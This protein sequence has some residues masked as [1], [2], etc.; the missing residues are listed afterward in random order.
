MFEDEIKT[1]RR[2]GVRAVLLQIMNFAMVISTGLMVWKGMGLATNTESPIVVVLS[3][4]MEPAFY[5]GDLLFLTNFPNIPYQIGDVT[6]YKIPGQDIPIVHRVLETHTKNVTVPTEQLLLT[7]G[8]NNALDDIEL[9]RGLRWLERKHIVGKV[10]GFLP[11]VG[12]ATIAMNFEIPQARI[13]ERPDLDPEAPF[14]TSDP[15]TRLALKLL[16]LQVLTPLSV[17]INVAANLVCALVISPSMADIMELFPNG[18]TPKTGMVGFYMTAVYVLLIGFCVLLITAR[19]PETKE[20]LVN[21]VGLRLVVVNWL[22]TAWAALWALQ[23]FIPSTIVLGIVALLL[24]W[25]AV[26]LFWYTPG[27]PLTRPFDNLFI[28]SPLKLWFLITITLDF[29]LSLFIALGWNYPYNRPDMYARKQW[30]AFAFIVSMHAL[31]VLWVFFRQD[32]IVTIGGLWIVLS[33]MLRR[34]KAAP[35]FAVLVIFAVLYPLTYISTMAWKRLKRHEQDEGRI[36]LPPDEEDVANGNGHGNGV[37]NQ[38]DA[39]LGSTLGSVVPNGDNSLVALPERNLK[40]DIEAGVKAAGK[41]L[42]VAADEI[43]SVSHK[44]A[45]VFGQGVKA[46]G[47][48]IQKAEAWLDSFAS[49][50]EP[51]GGWDELNDV[52]PVCAKND[53]KNSFFIDEAL[54]WVKNALKDIG[55]VIFEN[56]LATAGLVIGVSVLLIE[57]TIGG[58]LAPLAL[59]AI[60]FGPKGPIKNTIATAVQKVINPVKMGSVFSHLQ[61]AAMHRAGLKKLH[62]A[63]DTIFGGLVVAGAVGLIDAGI[64]TQPV[65]SQAWADW[66]SESMV[67]PLSDITSHANLLW[68]TPTYGGCVAYGYQEIRAPFKLA[69]ILE[70]VDPLAACEQTPALIEGTGFKTPL[71]C[72]D[73]GSKKGIAGLWYVPTNATECM[74][75]WSKFENEGCML[76]GRRRRFARL[77]G[78][79]N[80][81]DWK[82]VCESTPAT[83]DGKDYDYPSHCDD[84]GVGGIYGVFDIVDE[85]C[86]CSCAHT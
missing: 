82:G 47:K 14:D 32:L 20:T 65:H 73:E 27:G 60:G 26:S 21:G 25:I 56:P 85:Q 68:G 83:I 52:L 33:I 4:S 42:K 66:A 10:Q 5:R 86:E 31:G 76:Y 8:D 84:K 19:N 64:N 36:A 50:S 48:E 74:P 70:D 17:L 69:S 81:G 18:M 55:V 80:N 49:K 79:K 51:E 13:V 58:I 35:V 12:Y 16:R 46:A 54:R 37:V 34:P 43:K 77:M 40:D 28:H 11:Y 57:L 15:R 30:E 7:K 44:G 1:L 23:L 72:V 62:G 6:V 75:W 53:C 45:K 41:G 29:P 59:Q 22:M 71:R 9:Y 2:M 67:D 24:G 3:G 61:S 39:E 38:E 63:V 78:L